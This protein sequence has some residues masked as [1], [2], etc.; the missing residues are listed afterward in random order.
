MNPFLQIV[1][2]FTGQKWLPL[3][4]VLISYAT[5]AM[6]DTSKLPISIPDRWK[7]VLI[8]GLGQ[9][10]SVLQAETD[11]VPWQK[12]VWNGV[13]ASF[14]AMGLFAVAFKAIY[15]NGAPSWLSWIA[16]I[17]PELVNAKATIGLDTKL[18][19]HSHP[20][21]PPPPLPPSPPQ[22]PDQVRR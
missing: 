13:V 8:L 5:A 15:P 19:G 7:P 14:G 18:F 17:D 11:G 6:S 20:S 21:K 16:F 2:D 22:S 4:M 10:Y 12:A 1:Q 9:V 3:A